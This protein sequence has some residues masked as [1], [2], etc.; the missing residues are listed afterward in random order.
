M[1]QA[2]E[3]GISI[4]LKGQQLWNV[5]HGLPLDAIK[6][7]SISSWKCQ[8]AVSDQE[9]VS[10]VD[11]LCKNASLTTLDLSL[12]GFEWMPK[13]TPRGGR[14]RKQ[15]NA[16]ALPRPLQRSPLAPQCDWARIAADM[17]HACCGV[18]PFYALRVCYRTV[19][20]EE[21]NAMSNLLKAISSDPKAL[22][23]LKTLVI[24]QDTQW[25]IPIASLRSG[26]ETVRTRTRTTAY[27]LPRIALEHVVP[28]GFHFLERSNAWRRVR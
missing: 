4:A 10:L 2:R 1:P 3:A 7:G 23:A 16:L 18:A 20:R 11:A 19:E 21:R 13:G 5:G 25:P 28:R 27:T 22:E 9:F 6:S 26:P 8:Y 17:M 14:A 15:R 12:A 24:S